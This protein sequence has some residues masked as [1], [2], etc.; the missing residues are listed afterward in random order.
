MAGN[1][2]KIFKLPELKMRIE[3]ELK[4]D[5]LLYESWHGKP[6]KYQIQKLSEATVFITGPGLNSADFLFHFFQILKNK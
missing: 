4:L 5:V 1:R 6:M 2:R 3:E